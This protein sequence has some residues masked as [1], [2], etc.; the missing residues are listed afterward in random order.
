MALILV[1]D[2]GIRDGSETSRLRKLTITRANFYL[3]IRFVLR[4]QR[5]PISALV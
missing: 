1:C 5:G 3:V 4:V 2:G